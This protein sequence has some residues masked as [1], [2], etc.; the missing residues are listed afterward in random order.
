VSTVN[1]LTIRVD[2]V[3]AAIRRIELD[4]KVPPTDM[5]FVTEVLVTT[6]WPEVTL[7]GVTDK[8]SEKVQSMTVMFCPPER[9]VP[10]KLSDLIWTLEKYK[11]IPA[12]CVMK[13]R[14]LGLLTL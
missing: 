12:A 9:T 5:V 14:R 13:I 2:I 10:V 7:V 6:T 3:N 4:P 8:K 1:E 11:V